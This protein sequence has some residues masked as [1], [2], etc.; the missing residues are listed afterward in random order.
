MSPKR[1]LRWG[2]LSLVLFA[3]AVS[4]AAPQNNAAAHLD[5]GIALATKGLGWSYR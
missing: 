3:A 4:L 5:R 2:F 1:S